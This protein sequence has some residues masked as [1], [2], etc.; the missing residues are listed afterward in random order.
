MEKTIVIHPGCVDSEL[1]EDQRHPFLTD[2]ERQKLGLVSALSKR[3]IEKAKKLVV[4]DNADENTPKDG[5]VY[6][7]E[8]ESTDLVR[9]AINQGNKATIMGAYSDICVKN[10]AEKASEAGAKVK[11]PRRSTIASV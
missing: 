10:A 2:D 4:L 11:I 8:K 9:H 3:K 7:L 6:L 1:A 5:D